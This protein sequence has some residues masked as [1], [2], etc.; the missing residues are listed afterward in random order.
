MGVI[1]PALHIL[2]LM[3]V[4]AIS[5]DLHYSLHRSAV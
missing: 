2:A 5:Q 4:P 1:K 3:L